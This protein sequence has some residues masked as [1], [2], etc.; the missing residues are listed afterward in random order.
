LDLAFIVDTSDSI[1]ANDFDQVKQFMTETIGRMEIG[2]TGNHI[3]AISFGNNAE[4]F[5][6]FDTVT[7]ANLT[8]RN[9][10]N[11]FA[12]FPKNGG[13]TRIDL[14][15][16]LAETDVFTAANGMRTDS[17]IRKVTYHFNYI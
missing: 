16:L 6:R 7:G 14:A 4:I 17:D 15:L 12:N 1:N 8:R 5:I 3:A 13:L 2:P 11:R 10:I 9:L